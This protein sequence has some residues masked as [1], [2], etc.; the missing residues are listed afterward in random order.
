MATI[1]EEQ[2][3]FKKLL[4]NGSPVVKLEK[5]F[6]RFPSDH[7]IINYHAYSKSKGWS[8]EFLTPMEA[9]DDCLNKEDEV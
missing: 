5:Q 9:V 2:R 6:W 7:I 3:A 4:E 1:R 8:D